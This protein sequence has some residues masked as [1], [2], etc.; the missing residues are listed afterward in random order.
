LKTSEHALV[1]LWSA[2]TCRRFIRL[3][4]LSARQRRAERRGG[5]P[6]PSICA[7]TARL[8]TLDGDESP[9]ESGDESPHSKGFAVKL[10]TPLLER[11]SN[12]ASH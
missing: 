1:A 5:Q 6:K 9:A 2:T 7:K 8:T 11:A 3:A 10:A 4:D 12:T